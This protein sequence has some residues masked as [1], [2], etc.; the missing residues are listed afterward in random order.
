MYKTGSGLP[1]G[2]PQ[3]AMTQFLHRTPPLIKL[4]ASE[5]KATNGTRKK[6]SNKK[7]SKKKAKKTPK[8]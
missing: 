1:A 5:P 7:A 2:I 6:A 8:R 3:G 4:I